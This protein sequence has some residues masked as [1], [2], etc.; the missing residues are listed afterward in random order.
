MVKSMYKLTVDEQVL[1]MSPSSYSKFSNQ[2]T[3][4]LIQIQ[5]SDIFS[6]PIPYIRHE[7]KNM[8]YYPFISIVLHIEHGVFMNYIYE[9]LDIACDRF[10]EA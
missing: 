10:M 8:K 4:Y 3:D 1:I 9:E 2:N 5:N 7:G 6:T